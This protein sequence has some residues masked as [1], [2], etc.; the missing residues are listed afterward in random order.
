MIKHWKPWTL[1]A[2]MGFALWNFR[3]GDIETMWAAH[4]RDIWAHPDD[5]AVSQACDDQYGS[6]DLF[7]ETLRASYVFA[8]AVSVQ[9]E[10][11]C[12]N[13]ERQRQLSRML[14]GHFGNLGSDAFWALAWAWTGKEVRETLFDA[15]LTESERGE[16][17]LTTLNGHLLL[18]VR[19]MAHRGYLSPD[20]FMDMSSP[21]LWAATRFIGQN[22]C[23]AA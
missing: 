15:A 12:G 23:R 2:L 1:A 18:M 10:R 17:S 3:G 11:F 8:C 4:S 20:Y 5:F 22:A 13:P 7:R 9:P 16:M 21:F 14:K 19:E 6:S